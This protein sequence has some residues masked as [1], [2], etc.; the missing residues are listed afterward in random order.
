MYVLLSVLPIPVLLLAL[1]RCVAVLERLWP[2]SQADELSTPR[3]IHK[4]ATVDV[5]GTLALVALEQKRAIENLTRHFEA[6]RQGEN[7]RALR[8]ASRAL[9][10]YISA[11]LDELQTLHPMQ[12]IEERN[13][14]LNRQ[15]LLPWLEDAL[16]V[17]CHTLATPA[18]HPSL[19]ALRLSI[20]ESVDAVLLALVDAMASNDTL[21]W[22]IA[23]RLTGDRSAMM[24]RIREQ[25]LHANTRPS[26]ADMTNMLLTTN[27]VEEVFFVLSKLTDDFDTRHW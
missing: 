13:S 11:V 4:R 12:C 25:F 20:L 14:A 6:A 15:K 3:Y 8:E 7:I 5:E 21:S 26:N 9:F 16:G 27:A 19:E 24:R 18:Q 17:L 22:D 10:S 2:T 23:T 1:E